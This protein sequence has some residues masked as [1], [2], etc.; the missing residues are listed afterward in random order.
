MIQKRKWLDDFSRITGNGVLFQCEEILSMYRELDFDL[1]TSTIIDDSIVEQ[2][3]ANH[4]MYS[5][6]FYEE[7]AGDGSEPKVSLRLSG[8]NKRIISLAQDDLDQI[9]GAPM[10]EHLNTGSDTYGTAL[11]N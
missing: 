10:I 7:D 1:E 8:Y 3:T 6:L 11:K 5:V 9:D 2:H 4:R